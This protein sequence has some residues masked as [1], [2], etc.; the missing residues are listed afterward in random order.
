MIGMHNIYPCTFTWNIRMQANTITVSGPQKD[1]VLKNI[2]LVTGCPSGFFCGWA[3]RNA[4]I[5]SK[6]WVE[7]PLDGKI[8]R[9]IQVNTIQKDTDNSSS[10]DIN[11]KVW[12]IHTREL[13]QT[14]CKTSWYLYQRITQ[15]NMC[16]RRTKGTISV[17]RSV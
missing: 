1:T 10:C 8:V 9:I 15:N 14:L 13:R 17:I 16:E 6:M 12:N 11:A 3:S 5:A 4:R 2:D 7:R